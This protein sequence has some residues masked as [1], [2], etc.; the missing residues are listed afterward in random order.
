M[1]AYG[2]DKASD[3]DADADDADNEHERK[4]QDEQADTLASEYMT[5]TSRVP[6]LQDVN[7]DEGAEALRARFPRFFDRV[8]PAAMEAVLE[9]GDLLVM[10]PGWW[11]AMRGEG[12]GVCWS[13]SF[14]Y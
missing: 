6:I 5:N 1:Y 3:A 12:E 14:W 2:G 7:D 4:G 10:P 11:H 8:Y 13:V 9:P